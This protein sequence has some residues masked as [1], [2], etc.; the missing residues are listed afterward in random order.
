MIVPMMRQAEGPDAT[1]AWRAGRAGRARGAAALALALVVVHG[2]CGTII[3]KI[4][5]LFAPVSGWSK[6][7][8]T[9]EEQKRDEQSCDSA[10]V[11]AHGP[12]GGARLAYEN[13]MRAKGYELAAK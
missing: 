6:P 5:D 2:G 3:Q 9:D 10:A 12:G 11:K 4:E 7:G 13:C 8:V 1:G